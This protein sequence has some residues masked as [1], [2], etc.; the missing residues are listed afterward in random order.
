MDV[1]TYTG[2]GATQ[3][4]TL[5]FDPDL[6]WQKSRSVGRSHRLQDSVRGFNNVLVS[7]STAAEYA[8][9]SI[10]ATSSNGIT[11]NTAD[12]QNILSE[13]Y[14]AWSWDAGSTN[15]TNTSGSITSTVRANPQAGFSIATF[16]SPNATAYT[17]GHGLGISPKMVIVKASGAI[18]NW[19]VYHASVGNTGGLRLNLTNATDTSSGYWNNLSPT[20]S[21]VNVGSGLAFNS[22]TIAYCFAEIEGYSKFGSYTGNGS[23]DGPFVWCGFRPRWILIKSTIEGSNWLQWDTARMTFNQMP[24]Y[25]MP[26]SSNAETTDTTYSVD[27]VSNGFKIRGTGQFAGFNNNGNAYIFAAFAESPF[28]YARAR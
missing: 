23:A 11:L 9:S 16:T 7:D 10:S 1:V 18:S 13:T 5:Q 21:I 27:S 6:I 28:K 15:S 14:V 4:L 17:F 3:N 2:T 19:N 26:S 8:G 24:T 25:L 20:S 22:A 12:N